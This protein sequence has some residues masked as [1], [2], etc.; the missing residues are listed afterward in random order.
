[1]SLPQVGLEAVIAGLPGFEAGAQAINKAYD[2]IEA[3]AGKVERATNI[4]GSAFSSIGSP[5][6][7]L[8]NQF[9]NLG[10][11]VLKFGAVA[12]GVALAGVA[13]LTA[14]ITALGVS[15]V[16]EFA[17]YERLSL[18]IQNLVAR[19]ISQ[20]QVQEQQI[21][22]RVGL[23]K[24]ENEELAKLPQ[25]IQDETL[26]RATLSAQIQEQ[27][28]RIIDLT[29]S[30]G[31]NG[32][33]VQTAKAR[34]AE[35]ENEF[36]K[37]GQSITDMQARI[38]ELNDK[39]GKLVTTLQKVRVGQMGMAD[40]MKLAGPKAQELLKW[41]QL[42]AI[43]SPFNQE[44]IADAFQTALA[45]GFT[46]DKAQRLTNAEVDFAAATGKGVEA[47]N[48]IALAL[49]QMQAKGKVSG[50]EI[51]QLTN[52]GVGVNK[53][54]NDMGFTLDDVSKGLVK[55]D[56]FIEAVIKDMEVFKGSAKAQAG[57]FAGLIASMEDIKSIGL[58]EFFTGTFKA[59]QPYLANFVDFLTN[60]ALNTGQLRALGD[61]LGQ[62]VGGALKQISTFIAVIQA[63]GLAV[64]SK[65]LG[66]EGIPLWYQLETLITNITTSVTSLS[67]AA[68]TNLVP[69]FSQLSGQ[70]LPTITK[71]L[72]FVNE[73]FVEFKGALLGI[74][75]VLAA[76]VFAAIVAGVLSLLTPI[77]LIV[78]AA[79]LLGAAWAG[80]WGGIQEIVYSTWATI[81]PILSQAVTWLQVNIPAA[82]AT[83]S[84]FWSGTLLPALTT[85]GT[86]IQTNII[87][88]LSMVY[89]WLQTNLPAAIQLLSAFWSGTL[90]PAITAASD[91]ISGTLVPMLS[92]AWT[93]LQ[94]NLPAALQTLSATWTNT[95]LPAVVGVW[96]FWNGSLMPLWVS[97]INLVNAVV[98]KSIEALAGLFRNILLPAI[99][100]VGNFIGQ[101]LSPVI[102]ALAGIISDKLTPTTK[103]FS[104]DIIPMLLKG[105]EALK[106][107]I[108][109]V[110]GYFDALASAVNSF[111]LPEVL[112][113]HSPSP[114]E[115]VLIGVADNARQATTALQTLSRTTQGGFSRPVLDKLLGVK[116]GIASTSNVIGAAADD[117]EKIL[118]QGLSKSKTSFALDVLKDVFNQ[119]SAKILGAGSVKQQ[120]AMFKE[121]A[122][123]AVNWQKAGFGGGAE[124]TMNRAFDV[125][126]R[127]F[128]AR[129][130]ELQQMQQQIFIEAGRTALT[131]GNQLNDI[132]KSSADILSQRIDILTG[133]VNSGQGQVDY[134]GEIISQTEAQKKLNEALEEQRQIQK[135]LVIEQQNEMKLNFLEKQLSLI[136]TLSKAGLNVKD[137]LGGLKLGLDASIPDMIAATNRLVT[138]M[139][140]QVDQDLQISSP[141]KVMFKKGAYTGQGFVEGVAAQI[142]SAAAAMQSLVSGPAL[143]AAPALG[144]SG[145][146]TNNFYNDFGGNTISSGMDEATFDARVQRSILRLMRQ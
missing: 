92:L 135:E 71:A 37:S 134:Q 17:K 62:Y 79:A 20:G 39:N 85:A 59:I 41:I 144:A 36:A 65:Y 108:N 22:A 93:W 141:S 104:D 91:Y 133:L 55:S 70:I 51:I 38:S 83:A 111:T 129:Q 34:L 63:G 23:T 5:I 61:V 18:S 8:G 54:L 7:A 16:G 130:T 72:A 75:A 146:V 3:K 69:I 95:L 56:D 120:Q 81:Q 27:K 12:G 96:S 40:A 137:I 97:F 1:M 105:F 53:I 10:N 125:F 6:G 118:K 66:V 100:G 78:A 128:H 68:Q 43:Q 42:L 14:G 30:Y 31:E 47:T 44:G 24:K 143:V 136:E 106:Q 73:H 21:Q 140:D 119:N 124:N 117:V 74:G 19:E 90:L 64:F 57:T 99:V 112:Q 139:I 110:K 94:T 84:T 25:R 126:I 58:R 52:A 101:N 50:Q 77:N 45:Y 121:L 26:S 103:G 49:G 113:R 123:S 131:I 28:Q 2:A 98:N 122:N 107:I 138:A 33:N 29:A 132:V 46:T 80:D 109:D 9:V 127:Q 11:G 114:F 145:G 115:Q 116:R 35:M 142:G 67:G 86:F 76:G 89:T 60:A 102:T 15:A 4:L 82:I 88:T 48:M 32:L 87:P 13:A